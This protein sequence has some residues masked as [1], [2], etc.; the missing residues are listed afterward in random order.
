MEH[1]PFRDNLLFTYR[2]MLR[3]IAFHSYLNHQ[4]PRLAN[5]PVALFHI[6]VSSGRLQNVANLQSC[7][8]RIRNLCKDLHCPVTEKRCEG[9]VEFLSKPRHGPARCICAAT[10]W[11]L[12]LSGLSGLMGPRAIYIGSLIS[13]WFLFL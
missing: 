5:Y 11:T 8:I 1:C 10:K 12:G 4:R 6:D 9:V 2:V 13:S 3:F 7:P